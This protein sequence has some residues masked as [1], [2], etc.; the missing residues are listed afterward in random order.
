MHRLSVKCALFSSSFQLVLSLSMS[1]TGLNPSRPDRPDPTRCSHVNQFLEG[2]KLLTAIDRHLDPEAGFGG[3]ILQ[4]PT[5]NTSASRPGFTF[6]ESLTSPETLC[7]IR[8][9]DSS[10]H[11]TEVVGHWHPASCSFRLRS[12]ASTDPDFRR[13][14]RS[15]TQA[16]TLTS[17]G[18]LRNLPCSCHG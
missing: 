11:V 9:A 16:S 15:N 10:R 6:L 5:G 4:D 2:V 7:R 12:P 17:L 13:L 3:R 1:S 18:K 8:T 14:C